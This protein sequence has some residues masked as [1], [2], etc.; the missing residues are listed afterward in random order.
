MSA[1]KSSNKKIYSKH[2]YNLAD[3][4]K[5]SLF[6]NY[7]RNP[8]ALFEELLTNIKW[9]KFEYKVYDKMVKSPRFM[10]I[11]YFDNDTDLPCLQNIKTRIEKI[12]GVEFSYA[13]LNYYR[14]GNDYISYHADREVESGQIVVSVSLGAKR[15][16]ILKH[17]YRSDVKHIFLLDDGDVLI[18]NEAAIKT[19]YKHS[20]PK[21]ANVGPRINIT[22]RE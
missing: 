9:K 16:F 12:T 22:F 6:P 2:N 10:H 5:V 8:D 21:M 20:V 11:L 3:G 7:V 18:L 19:M 15:R 13:V 4:A 1:K 14:D 17:K